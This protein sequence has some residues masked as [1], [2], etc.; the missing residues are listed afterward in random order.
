MY[1]FH[2]PRLHV[3]KGDALRTRR[4]YS[5]LVHAPLRVP[6]VPTVGGPEVLRG[7]LLG[8]EDVKTFVAVPVLRVV[9][10][11]RE[12]A[13]TAP[14]LLVLEVSDLVGL[15]VLQVEG[16]LHQHGEG[17]A[18]EHVARPPVVGL[19]PVPARQFVDAVSQV[20]RD[21]PPVAPPG[22]AYLAGGEVGAQI[23]HDEVEVVAPQ[24]EEVVVVV[25]GLVDVAPDAP[26]LHPHGVIMFG[27]EVWNVDGVELRVGFVGGHH[28]AVALRSPRLPDGI[29]AVVKRLHGVHGA[30][31]PHGPCALPSVRRHPHPLRHHLQ[32]RLPQV[33]LVLGVDPDAVPLLPLHRQIIVIVARVPLRPNSR[34][35]AVFHPEPPRSHVVRKL[36]GIPPQRRLVVAVPAVPGGVQRSHVG[37]PPQLPELLPQPIGV[38]GVPLVVPV[39]ALREVRAVQRLPDPVGA[40]D[41]AVFVFGDCIVVP[42]G[43]GRADGGDAPGGREGV[44]A[45]EPVDGVVRLGGGALQK[46]IVF[47]AEGEE[48]GNKHHPGGRKKKLLEG[49]WD[50]SGRERRKKGRRLGNGGVP[51]TPAF[52]V[53]GQLVRFVLVV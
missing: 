27:P 15:A 30:E 2:E 51:I 10:R 29:Q 17:G 53:H 45:Q 31:D 22:V 20:E 39:A 49:R 6:H 9:R 11:D 48:E 8:C 16:E 23:F 38:P 41:A 46:Q 7:Q 4:L 50:V 1:L 32:P 14:D 33:V 24:I 3:M 13:E 28:E 42:G 34:V 47:G 52:D 5:E 35:G 18:V 40:L 25:V 26:H 43:D 21:R 12:V 36:R 37:V 44:A 19:P